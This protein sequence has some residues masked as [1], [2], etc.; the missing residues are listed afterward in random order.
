VAEK[1]VLNPRCYYVVEQHQPQE[2]I[3]WG[4]ARRFE[5][6][7]AH[8]DGFSEQSELPRPANQP[9]AAPKGRSL[10]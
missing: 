9:G 10:G 5:D 3:D 6:A 1:F 4:T 2:V 7:T 8:L